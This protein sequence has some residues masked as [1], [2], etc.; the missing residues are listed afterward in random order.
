MKKTNDWVNFIL[1]RIDKDGVET[2]TM[3]GGFYSFISKEKSAEVFNTVTSAWNGKDLEGVYA[4]ITFF[5][6]AI[7]P[8]YQDSSYYIMTDSG[9]TIANRTNK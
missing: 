3:L 1:R 9:G 6:D 4:V 2:D 7:M 8:L 5:D